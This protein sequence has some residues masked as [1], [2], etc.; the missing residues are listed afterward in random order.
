MNKEDLIKLKQQLK[1]LTEIEEQERNLYLKGLLEGKIQGPLTG[2][3]SIDKPWLKYYKDEEI[4]AKMPKMSMYRYL[5]ENNKDYQENVALSYYGKKITFKELFENIEKTA[6]AL[7]ALGVKENEAISI[8][9]PNIPE[10]IYFLYA[11]S[12]IGAIANMIDPRASKE[13][14]KNYIKEAKA[15]KFITLPGCYDNIKDLDLNKIITVSPSE[16]LPLFIKLL[17]KTKNKEQTNWKE[18][19][20]NGIKYTKETEVNY[21]ENRPVLIEHTGGTTGKPKSVLLSNDNLNSVAFQSTMTT[22]N[23]QKDQTWLGFIPSFI[24]NGAGIGL[25]LPLTVGME[26]ILVPSFDPEKFDELI[27]K[28]NPNHMVISPTHWE[29]ILKSK[30]M[31]NKDLSY[32]IAPSVGGDSM[33][34]VLENNVNQFLKE[35]NCKYNVVKGYG[36]TEVTGGVAGATTYNNQVGSTGIPFVK[37]TIS[38]FKPG[39]DEELGYN[40]DGEICIS[41]P[42]TM[43]GYIDNEE[44]TK[45]ILKEHNDGKIWVHTGDIGYMTEDGNIFLKDRIKRIIIRHDG[46][47][48]FPSFIEETLLLHNAVLNCKVVAVDDE[49]HTQGQLPKAF[50]VLKDEYKNNEEQIKNEL[51][52]LCLAKLPKYSQPVDYAIKDKLPLT[53]IDKIDYRKLQE[54]ENTSKTLIKK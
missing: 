21:Y 25:H 38:I 47:K 26:T 44:A 3:P 19:I 54:E 51:M 36:M 43:L 40:Q 10:T 32:M 53:K 12:K 22:N 7:K 34:T 39:T 27:C 2:M 4:I 28:Y 31:K 23:L 11:V 29:P 52:E 9:L 37:Q 30:K 41:G 14:I 6:K 49:E 1:G 20:N 24:A 45:G 50:I 17:Y 16:S 46:F 8:S 15:N 35:H 33:N 48:I 13:D 5:Y 42:N 18:F